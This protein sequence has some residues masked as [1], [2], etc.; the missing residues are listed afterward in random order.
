M[1]TGPAKERGRAAAAAR[2]ATLLA[3]TRGDMVK[4]KM[5]R[6]SSAEDKDYCEE[7][8]LFAGSVV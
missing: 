5:Y 1:E 7:V 6:G 4:M 8:M 2:A 3:L